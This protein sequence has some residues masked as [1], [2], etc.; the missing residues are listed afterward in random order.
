MARSAS[1]LKPL[2]ALALA[3]LGCLWLAAPA[4]AAPTW[5]QPIELSESGSEPQVAANAEGD[6]VAI[7]ER[8]EGSS[9]V[10]ETSS[11]PAGGEWGAAVDLGPAGPYPN[12]QPGFGPNGKPQVAIGADGAA[13]ATWLGYNGSDFVIES[14]SRSAAGQWSAAAELSTA[15]EEPAAQV[16]IDA[17]GTA[18][19][20]WTGANRTPESARRPA[21]GQW[22]T[23]T[24]LSTQSGSEPQI[25]LDAAGDSTAVWSIREGPIQIASRPAGGQWSIPTALSAA[26]Q[27]ASSPEIA[28]DGAGGAVAAWAQYET[29]S[30]T[31]QSA[32]RPAGGQWSAQTGLSPEGQSSFRPHIAADAAGDA[33]L[34]WER[35]VGSATVV[36]STSRPA[37]GDWSTPTDLSAGQD[38]ALAQLAMNASGD[39]VAVWTR[40]L[41]YENVIETAARPAGGQWGPPTEFSAAGGQ[42]YSYSP[43]VAMDGGGDAVAVWPH[44]DG[45]SLTIQAAG[46]DAA[47][48]SIDSLSIPTSG[49]T[50]TPLSLSV[51]TFDV[52]SAVE[53]TWSFGDGSSARGKSVSHTYAHPGEYEVTV[54]ATD[55]VGNSSSA[56]GTIAVTAKPAAVTGKL[57]P[58]PRV[59]L[60]YTPNHSHKPDPAGGPRYTFHFSDQN[61]EAS[62]DCRLDDTRFKPCTSP[63][64]YRHLSRGRHVLRVK[65]H[66]PDGEISATRIVHFYAGRRG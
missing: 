19:A 48:P 26:G 44:Y 33:V 5:L 51:S 42:S 1:S 66:G 36:E 45:S 22:S 39:A 17:A 47:D 37:N 38:A 6:A 30:R 13:V 12:S 23:P 65:S 4:L 24:E 63:S 18:V 25:A 29:S 11:R 50:G 34:I 54:T 2:V 46:Y 53:P 28:I 15:A 41:E 14:A 62:F 31:I 49:E 32:S 43:Q 16:A 27:I 7:W 52:W 58:A 20:I 59:R 35:Y 61:P 9:S 57:T 3:L 10:I 21:G 56:T 64:V 60:L 40:V 8:S 55:A